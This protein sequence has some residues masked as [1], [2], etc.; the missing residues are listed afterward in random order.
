LSAVQI[1]LFTSTGKLSCSKIKYNHKTKQ[2]V[3]TTCTL[4]LGWVENLCKM[5]TS[6]NVAEMSI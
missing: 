1:S 6:L 2:N 5:D 4:G 3:H